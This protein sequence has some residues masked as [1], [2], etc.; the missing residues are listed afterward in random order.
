MAAWIV[1]STIL[2]T[3]A[4]CYP[5]L[6]MSGVRLR[7]WGL[8]AVLVA[9]L[10][11]GGAPEPADLIGT[12]EGSGGE[13]TS[14]L[15]SFAADGSF[16]LEYADAKGKR[17]ELTGDYEA[18]FTK[19]PIAVSFRRIKQLP[20]PLHTIV[21]FESA[22]TLRMGG[23]APRWRLRPVAFDADSAIVLERRLAN[24]ETTS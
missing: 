1:R 5:D 6:V 18:D 4:V 10:A 23:F 12:W 22:D 15:V 7:A 8:G 16:R 21:E 2:R 20:H 13:M 24:E 11:C 9:L 14:V 19:A 3:R 17:Q